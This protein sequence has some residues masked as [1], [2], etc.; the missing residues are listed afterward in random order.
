[1][2]YKRA[3]DAH[4]REYVGGVEI[5][6]ETSGRIEA[7]FATLNVVDLDGDVTTPGAFT[8]GAPVMISDWNHTSWGAAKPVG[9]GFIYEDGNDVVLEGQFFMNTTHG[10]D[11][12]E[13]VKEL[14]ELAS[15]SYGF[16]VDDSKQAP[17]D[18]SYGRQHRRTLR[19]MT[20]H[21]VSPVLVAA[22]VNTRLLAVKSDRRRGGIAGTS[23]DA[24]AKAELQSLRDEFMRDEFNELKR[25]RN[26]FYDDVAY[27]QVLDELRGIAVTEG[28][29]A[30]YREVGGSEVPAKAR[31]AATATLAR[32]HAPGVTVRWFTEESDPARVEFTDTKIAGFCRPQAVP[33]EIWLRSDL[34]TEKTVEICAHEIAHLGGAD[35]DTA[36]MA[37]LAALFERGRP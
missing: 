3:F 8:E 23:L 36:Q 9:K 21:E 29:L 1:M 17:P 16:D 12:F 35:E 27:A 25:L 2:E 6:S 37:G 10:R 24:A 5:K 28:F 26:R 11:A 31:E 22:G 15:F 34:G 32:L 19:K 18:S 20:V 4:G 33:D 30:G 7:V 14:G 13:T